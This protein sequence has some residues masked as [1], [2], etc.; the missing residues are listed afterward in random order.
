MTDSA[1]RNGKNMGGKKKYDPNSCAIL[2]SGGAAPGPKEGRFGTAQALA[3]RL[4]LRTHRE[5][6]LLSCSN[7]ENLS[8]EPTE[9]TKLG[10]MIQ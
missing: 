2:S 1:E 4:S 6:P 7:L 10:P 3:K 5:G 8:Q 9:T